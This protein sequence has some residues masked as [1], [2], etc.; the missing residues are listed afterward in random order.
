[1]PLKPGEFLIGSMGSRSEADDVASNGVIEVKKSGEKYQAT[2]K[3]RSQEAKCSFGSPIACN[4]RAYFVN[5]SGVLNCL[6]LNSGKPIF[7]GRL[8]SGAIWA[9]P[10]A[11]KDRVYFFGKDGSTAILKASD[12]L[13]V[14]AKNELWKAEPKKE[15]SEENTASRF[16][17]T[18]LYAAAVADE[19]LIMRRGDRLYAIANKTK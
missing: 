16:G 8:P 4:D 12:S 17:G 7:K 14:V 3:W 10:L 18:V 1:M 13:E 11:T 2:W 19:K 5:R 9:T 6:Q 15:S